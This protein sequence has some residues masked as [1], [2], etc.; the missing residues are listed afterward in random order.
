MT[1]QVLPNL[2]PGREY[3]VSIRFSDDLVDR[4]SNYSGPVCAVAPGNRQAASGGVGACGGFTEPQH[5]SPV[6]TDDSVVCADALIAV[7]VCLLLLVAMVMVAMLGAAGYICPSRKPLPRILVG[8]LSF[9]LVFSSCSSF[10]IL[11]HSLKIQ[12]SS[13]ISAFPR[14]STRTLLFD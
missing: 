10:M 8:K 6:T 4:N 13:Q 2:N 14:N 12:I 9:F 11:N 7:L 1:R 3:C 5:W